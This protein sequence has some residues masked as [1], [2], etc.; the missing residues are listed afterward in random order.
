[1]VRQDMER[2]VY[3]TL[4]EGVCLTCADDLMWASD[5]DTRSDVRHGHRPDLALSRDGRT[6]WVYGPDAMAG[7]CIDEDGAGGEHS[8]DKATTAVRHESCTVPLVCP[9]AAAFRR[10]AE[11]ARMR[12]L[13]RVGVTP[14]A[15]PATP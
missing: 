5:F 15:V 14:M 13:D 11:P 2:P 12:W 1:M 3:T 7:R 8:L 10:G 9:A 4:N 6:V